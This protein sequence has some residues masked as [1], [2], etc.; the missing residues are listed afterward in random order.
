MNSTLPF[1]HTLIGRLI[2][3]IND[4]VV[5]ATNYVKIRIE[6]WKKSF[7]DLIESIEFFVDP[8]KNETTFNE[9]TKLKCIFVEFNLKNSEHFEKLD[10]HKILCNWNKLLEFDS[11]L[12][13]IIDNYIKHCFIINPLLPS[14]EHLP[15]GIFMDSR[16]I[17]PLNLTRLQ[18]FRSAPNISET[19]KRYNQ[20]IISTMNFVN[21]FGTP[22]RK[23]ETMN[24]EWEEMW[25][26]M[27]ER[28]TENTRT[29]DPES[30]ERLLN[31]F[32]VF[33][34]SKLK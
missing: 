11:L 4:P 3:P 25:K 14:V 1:V 22:I 5:E 10:F 33:R 32:Y 12:I 34:Q 29:Q 24:K 9:I 31:V 2:N 13:K 27:T 8:L 30:L 6:S 26:Q 15:H 18:Y 23:I 16:F 20:L 17:W 7:Q 21:S 28:A 19:I